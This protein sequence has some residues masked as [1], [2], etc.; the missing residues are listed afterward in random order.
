L[1]WRFTSRKDKER[2]DIGKACY[3]KVLM[4]LPI[5]NNSIYNANLSAQKP[6]ADGTCESL[7]TT[8]EVLSPLV[9]MR[10][11]CSLPDEINQG[12][13]AKAA[14]LAALTAINLPEDTRDIKLA[15]KQLMKKEI[16]EHYKVAQVPFST[17]RGTFLEPVVN[18]LGKFGVKLHQM[19]IPL[20]DTKFGQN[21][22]NKFGGELDDFVETPI[23]AKKIINDPNNISKTFIDTISV[24]AMKYEGKPFGK[25][26]A[27]TLLRIPLLSTYIMA[28]L[29]LPSIYKAFATPDKAE[30]KAICGTAQI[31]KS[32][33][34][35]TTITAAVGVFG[36]LLKGKGPVGS[37]VG[38]ALGSIAGA[39]AA[40]KAD[41]KIDDMACKFKTFIS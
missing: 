13:Y 34:N 29:E 37:L 33:V 38:M 19:D 11:M 17:F 39:Y 22:I 23:K 15:A 24:D 5:Q 1:P 18:K 3:G 20:E 6:I 27:N 25:L 41:G 14:G 31:A 10:R 16:S 35:M 26:V 28:G 12:H 8:M 32:A 30:D 2:E 4:V 7:H 36:A 21:L 40:K 9:P